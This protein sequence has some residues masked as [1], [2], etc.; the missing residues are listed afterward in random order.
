MQL[1]LVVNSRSGAGRSAA[2]VAELLAGPGHEV[3][4]FAIDEAD[5]AARSGADRVVLA[6]GDG[7]VGT[8]FQA[9]ARHRVPLA[10]LPAGTANDFARALGI[11]PGIEDAAPIAADPDAERRTVWGGSIDGQPFVNVASIGLGVYA[12]EQAAPL[13]RVLGPVAYGIGAA[14]ATVR[15]RVAR[16]RVIVDGEELFDGDVWQVLVAASGSFGGGVQLP[17]SDPETPEL[18]A[19]VLPSGPRVSLVRRAWG[20]RHGGNRGGVQVLQGHQIVVDLD[21]DR[22]WN[23]DGDLHPLG[24]VTVTPLGPVEVLV[25]RDAQGAAR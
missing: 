18:E 25:P 10:V 11:P 14:I 20:M 12:A 21:P 22:E 3:E 8:A 6:G 9:C 23:V 13:K 16:A 7:S 2:Q 1:A 19:F 5:A 4:T 17:V 15:G 24:D